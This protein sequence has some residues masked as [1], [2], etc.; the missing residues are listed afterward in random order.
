MCFIIRIFKKYNGTMWISKS[1][2]R[3]CFKDPISKW[4]RILNNRR[5]KEK[6][7]RKTKSNMSSKKFTK[8][9]KKTIQRTRTK[10]NKAI[11]KTTIQWRRPNRTKHNKT[12]NAKTFK[13]TKVRLHTPTDW[14]RSRPKARKVEAK[15]QNSETISKNIEI[16]CTGHKAWAIEAK[17]HG[18]VKGIWGVV[19]RE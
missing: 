15:Q 2:T 14:D 10:F 1:E 3:R 11:K 12:N 19:I 13:T 5:K 7:T 4:A 16:P 17:F 6:K 9:S 8:F 18:V